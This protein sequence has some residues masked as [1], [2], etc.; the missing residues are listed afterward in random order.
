M[1]SSKNKGVKMP[2]IS[3][4]TGGLFGSGTAGKINSYAPTDAMNT[5]TNL[6]NQGIQQSLEQ[7]LN[8]SY[9]GEI[10]KA[11]TDQRNRLASQSFENNLINPM[12]S[13][14]LARGSS[15]NSMGNSF[16]NTLANLEKDAM[17]EEDSRVANILQNMLGVNSQNYNQMLGLQSLYSGLAGNK[18]NADANLTASREKAMGDLMNSVA[19]A[20]AAAAAS[21]DRRLKENIKLLDEVGGVRIYEFDF[22]HGK[23][24]RVGVIAQEIKEIMPDIVIKDGDGFYGVKYDL[25]PAKVKERIKELEENKND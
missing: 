8:P 24:N 5:Q 12:A 15:V 14:G 10:F 21:S 1:G 17:A 2:A 7:M 25:L 23:K 16:A 4:D 6:A 20:A 3:Y 22:I 13:R 18:M 19:G 9:D 11:R